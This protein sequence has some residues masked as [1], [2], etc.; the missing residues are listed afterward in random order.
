M[1]KLLEQMALE[2]GYLDDD[3][4][5][6][7]SSYEDLLSSLDNNDVSDSNEADVNDYDPLEMV[8]IIGPYGVPWPYVV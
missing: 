1:K 3:A 6:S 5:E 4:N 8:E 7:Y 2:A